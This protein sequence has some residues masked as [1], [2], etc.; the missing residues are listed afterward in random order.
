MN[1]A[2]EFMDVDGPEF[3]QEVN[4]RIASIRSTSSHR[5]Q[6]IHQGSYPSANTPN[7]SSYQEIAIVDTNFLLSNLGTLNALL[8]VSEGRPGSLLLILPWQV[9]LE[10]DG[11]KSKNMDGESQVGLSARKAMKFLEMHLRDKKYAIRGQRTDEVFDKKS[12]G[13]DDA[14]LDC[15]MYFQQL[16]TRR[17]TLL[18]NDRN[19]CIKVMVHGVDSLSAESKSGLESLLN[20][21]DKGNGV[22]QRVNEASQQQSVDYSNGV[23]QQTVYYP[24]HVNQTEDVDMDIDG[25]EIYYDDDT[26]T[27]VRDSDHSKWAV[28]EEET[29]IAP[30]KDRVIM[31]NYSTAKPSNYS[32]KS[33]WSS[34]HA[35]K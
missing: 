4:T 32:A 7:P 34:I 6:D 8:D 22:D 21:V 14:I 31:K 26:M 17:L 1:G 27:E 28:T 35:P 5:Q 19:L 10:L 24:I 9:I 2:E 29:L 33:S 15:C 25:E 20:R 30:S 18:S 11:L 12:K 23:Q 3:I 13:G 16:T